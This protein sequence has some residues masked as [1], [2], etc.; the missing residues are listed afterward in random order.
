MMSP[1][2]RS[3]RLGGIVALAGCCALL[4]AFAASAAGAV[5]TSVITF[6][7][8]FGKGASFTV[9]DLP[10]KGKNEAELSPGDEIVFVVP[11][12][13]KNKKIGHENAVCVVTKAPKNPDNDQFLCHGTFALRGQGAL[14]YSTSFKPGKTNGAI[15]GGTGAFVGARGTVTTGNETKSGADVTITLLE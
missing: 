9:V 3:A 2:P 5:G 6:K 10:P 12:V 14:F 7:E 15:V 1:K 4:T 8:S 13:K 11:L